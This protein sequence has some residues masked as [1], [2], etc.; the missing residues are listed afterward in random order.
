MLCGFP[1]DVSSRDSSFAPVGSGDCSWGRL[2]WQLKGSHLGAHLRQGKESGIFAQSPVPAGSGSASWITE[3]GLWHSLCLYFPA[4]T[5]GVCALP[6]PGPGHGRVRSVA[7]APWD[8]PG[9]GRGGELG[10]EPLAPS[11]REKS[12]PLAPSGPTAPAAPSGP[13][14]AASSS[15]LLAGPLG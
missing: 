12:I 11:P 7:T 1:E 15:P 9:S 14:P 6:E 8:S 2:K 10:R 3:E 13:S 4:E 5:R